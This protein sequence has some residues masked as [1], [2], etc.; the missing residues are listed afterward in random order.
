MKKVVSKL[1]LKATFGLVGNDQLGAK[2]DRFYY[3]SEVN[4]NNGS[5]G[6]TWG[7]DYTGLHSVNG[8]SINRYANDD[9]TWETS[10][11]T[12]L[13]VEIGLFN[14]LELQVDVY[15]DY[16]YNILMSRA[17][18]PGS[19]GLQASI[20]SNLGE[21]IS[22]GIDISLDY[23]HAFKNGSYMQARANLTWAGGKYKVYEEPDYSKTPWL[24]R[25]DQ[26]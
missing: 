7:N 16:R 17:S 22:Q 2:E 13:G 9:I 21:A 19:M 20:K 25:I 3:R 26:N 11:K 15:R 14:D 12:N 4:L 8:V 18:L 6:Y 5:Y 23:N 24:S 10:R 1:K